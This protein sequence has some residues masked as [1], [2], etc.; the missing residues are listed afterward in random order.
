KKPLSG[1]CIGR[2]CQSRIAGWRL[3]STDELRKVVNIGQ[4]QV[5]RSVFDVGRGF[6]NCRD[7]FWP[8]TIGDAHLVQISVSDK[9]EKAAMLILPAEAAHAGLSWGFKN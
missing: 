4:A 2:R 3:G 1:L 9:G 5:I 6:A 7:I 8:Q